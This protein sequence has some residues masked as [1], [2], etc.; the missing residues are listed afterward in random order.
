M[1]AII[2]ILAAMLL[3]ALNKAKIQA[4]GIQCMNNYKQLTLAWVS[5]GQ[6]YKD[7]L[8][9]NDENIWSGNSGA[10]V[11]TPAGEGNWASG[12]E[13]WSGNSMNT[14]GV[15]YLQNPKMAVLAP[16]YG[17]ASKIYKCP[18]DIYLSAPQ[19]QAHFQARIR[20]V[21][22]DA[23]MGPGHPGAKPTIGAPPWRTLVN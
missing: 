12:W 6:D 18:A 9:P 10:T 1:I 4:Q 8:A 14:N 2:A 13:D 15:L 5:Y 3:P 19:H 22:M 11:A 20:S 21:S 16:Y 23:W 7:T 17:S